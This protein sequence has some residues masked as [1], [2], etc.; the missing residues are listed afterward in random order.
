MRATEQMN[1]MLMAMMQ[2]NQMLLAMLQMEARGDHEAPAGMTTADTPDPMSAGLEPPIPSDR[3]STTSTS[4]VQQVLAYQGMH[5]DAR[6]T[7]REWARVITRISERELKRAVQFGAL[8][9]EARGVGKDHR[10]Q[11]IRVA[12]LVRYLTSCDAVRSGRAQMPAWWQN[13]K[14][15]VSAHA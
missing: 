4:A 3:T 8:A 12:D 5:P 13:V 7:A 6:L 2:M 10:A 15:G 9:S 14:K 11:V 1:Q